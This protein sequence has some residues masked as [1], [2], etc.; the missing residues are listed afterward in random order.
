MT[1][2]TLGQYRH[3]LVVVVYLHND[4]HTGYNDDVMIVQVTCSKKKYTAVL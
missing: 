4:V 2:E 1:V 3:D